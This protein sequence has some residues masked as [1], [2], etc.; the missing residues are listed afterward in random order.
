MV[1][2]GW[3]VVFSTIPPKA[4]AG[5]WPCFLL[6]LIYVAL[7]MAVIREYGRLFACVVETPQSVVAIVI[8]T[9]GICSSDLI[10]SR[11]TA[12]KSKS[13]DSSIGYIPGINSIS[14]FIG[15]GVPWIIAVGYYG[16]EED[17]IF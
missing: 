5:G 6:S 16:Y 7:M 1:T 2:I 17:R 9:V 8:M 14:V 15:L 3:K 10:I 13:A 4:R 11:R 12:K